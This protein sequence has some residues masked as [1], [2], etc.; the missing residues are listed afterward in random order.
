MFLPFRILNLGY[1]VDWTRN[2]MIQKTAS[3][4]SVDSRVIYFLLQFYVSL[5]LVVFYFLQLFGIECNNK[6]NRLTHG[7]NH[8]DRFISNVRLSGAM[9]ETHKQK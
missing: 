1:F 9:L 8:N 4:R 2:G 3:T 6:Q 5:T 7:N